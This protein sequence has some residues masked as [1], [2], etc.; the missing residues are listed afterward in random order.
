MNRYK[1]IFAG[2]VIIIVVCSL[3]FYI[4][5]PKLKARYML[6]DAVGEDY[7]NSFMELR[8][9][10]YTSFL[11]PK[12]T[13]V[14]DYHIQVGNYSATCEAIFI[15][16]WI[17]RLVYSMGVPPSDNLMPFNVTQEE[18]INIAQKQVTQRYLE[19]EAQILFVERS[20][21]DV[22]LNRYVWQV[23]F[24]LT[25]KSAISGTL[26]EVLI[27]LHNGEVFDV[28]RLAWTSM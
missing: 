19:V 21:N 8:G 26:I 7:L 13:V 20:V 9:V 16:D 6:I 24:Y 18:A 10:Q 23:I 11:P 28:A 5:G 25:E 3:I 12:S 22:P 17:N 15:F 27:D 2:V 14:Y 4:Q 1:P